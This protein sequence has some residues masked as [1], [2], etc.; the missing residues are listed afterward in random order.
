MKDSKI[1]IGAWG[2]ITNNQ[3]QL[4]LIKRKAFDFW[5]SVGGTLEF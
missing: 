2:L 1:L 3:N 5:E 4:L